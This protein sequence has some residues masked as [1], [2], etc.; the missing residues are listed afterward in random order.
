MA[1]FNDG[2]D[3]DDDNND[4]HETDNIEPDESFDDDDNDDDDD[5]DDGDDNDDDKDN[6]VLDELTLFADTFSLYN[7]QYASTAS[8]FNSE[9]KIQGDIK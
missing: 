8:W 6:G 9:S 4:A 1:S 2:D 5:D 7:C 3:D